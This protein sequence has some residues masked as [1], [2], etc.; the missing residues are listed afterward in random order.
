MQICASFVVGG[1]LEI[2]RLLLE[3]NADTNLYNAILIT[4][5]HLAALG[6]YQHTES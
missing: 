3:A 6:W 4:P 1:H 5:L 2:V